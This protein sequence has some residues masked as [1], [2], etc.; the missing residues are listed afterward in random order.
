KANTCNAIIS[1][2]T[3]EVKTCHNQSILEDFSRQPAP[4]SRSIEL[5][6]VRCSLPEKWPGDRHAIAKPP[7]PLS[8]RQ[9]VSESTISTPATITDPTSRTRSFVKLFILIR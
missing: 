6:T 8:G 4:P 7:S 3:T 1:A 9:F 2:P 5:D